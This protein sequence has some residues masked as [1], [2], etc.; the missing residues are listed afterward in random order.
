VGPQTLLRSELLELVLTAGISSSR[1][2]LEIT[3]HASITEYDEVLAA[4]AALRALGVRLAVDDAG[5]GYASF[6][7]ILRLAPEI[8]KLDR[9]LIAGLHQDPALR[10]LAAAVVTFALETSATVTAEG[11]ETPEELRCAQDLG[12]HGA[13]GYLFGKPA[14]DWSTWNEWHARGAVYSVTAAGMAAG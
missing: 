9:S 5:A 12:I 8:I 2:V 6:R 1:I 3:E 14:A 4:V 7:H 10:A 13:Q 11:I